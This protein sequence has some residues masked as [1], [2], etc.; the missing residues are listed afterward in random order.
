MFQFILYSV[1]FK[2]ILFNN[3]IYNKKRH[4]DL[5]ERESYLRK[6]IQRVFRIT[7]LQM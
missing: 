7:V 3:I 6:V 2:N 5:R 1:F 4:I